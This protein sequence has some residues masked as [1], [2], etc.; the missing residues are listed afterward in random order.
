MKKFFQQLRPLEQRLVIVTG[1]IVFVLVNWVFV[2]PHFSDWTQIKGQLEDTK[3]T[4]VRFDKEIRETPKWDEQ[5]KKLEGEGSVL[6]SEEMALKLRVF[7]DDQA[8]MS[9]LI[10]NG[11]SISGGS[12]RG[13]ANTGVFEERVLTMGYIAGDNEMV[14]FLYN[15]GAGKSTIRVRDLT[16][17]PDGALAKLAGSMTLIASY[18]KKTVT[19]PKPPPAVK[20]TN[21]P[22]VK[23]AV[24]APL[25]ENVPAA[26]NNRVPPREFKSKM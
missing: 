11:V 18:Q 26:T 20:S 1:L 16:I 10:E 15:L 25:A 6:P 12:G 2:W 5:R 9:G 17:K 8:S 13:G 7:V 4:I 19:G 22:V 3:K 21:A 14:D 23:P 24:K